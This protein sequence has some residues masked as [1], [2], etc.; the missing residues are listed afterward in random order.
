MNLL[1]KSLTSF[2]IK[3]ILIKSTTVFL[4]R[5]SCYW[6]TCSPPFPSSP[7]VYSHFLLVLLAAGQ[8]AL[9]VQEVDGSH[10]QQE[11]QNAH[12]HGY[13]HP[14][15]ASLLLVGYSAAME[16]Y[17]EGGMVGWRVGGTEGGRKT[18][19][20]GVKDDHS[21]GGG[22][23]VRGVGSFWFLKAHHEGCRGVWG[24]LICGLKEREV[25][26]EDNFM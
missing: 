8:L 19:F 18:W 23:K 22:R 4:K 1:Q 5:C 24:V 21:R 6:V 16:G 26:G 25:G 14:A 12:H 7:P 11:Q 13:H 10:Q 20:G 3:D 17:M 2:W 15:G 9:L